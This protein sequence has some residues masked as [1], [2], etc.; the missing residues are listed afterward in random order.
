MADDFLVEP[1][2][3]ESR[4]GQPGMVV[5]DC[6]WFVPEFG[7]SGLDEFRNGHIAG[8]LYIDL[9]DIS[10]A[11]SPYVNML[12]SQAQFASEI[13]RLGISNNTLV[14]VCDAN[15][16]SARVWWMFRLFGHDRVRILN[17]GFRR[18]VAEGRPVETGDQAPVMPAVFAATPPAAQV[19]DWRQVL[20]AIDSGEATIA[21]ARTPGRFTGELSSGYPGVAGGH[22][23]TAVNIAW[24]QLIEQDGQ[25][26]FVG[27]EEVKR[28]LVNASVDLDKP[29]IATCGSGVTAAII[30][31]QLERMGMHDWRIYDASWHEWGQRT[32]LP[33][34]S[35]R[36]ERNGIGKQDSLLVRAG[37]NIHT[38]GSS[39]NPPVVRAS[40]FVF[41]TLDDFH[42]A[43]AKPF[44]GPF[45]GRIG[46][47]VT[48]A[49]EKAVAALEGG[50]SAIATSSGL[51]AIT[52]V[53]M[54]FLNKG[55]HVLVPDSVYDP[56]RRL[57][58]RTLSRMGI[59]T[60]YYD[61][62]IGAGIEALI[63]PETRLIYM[64]SPGSGTFEV[65]DVP[66][67]VRVAKTRGIRT[68]IDSTWATPLF[69]KP[70]KLG[71]DATIQAA[72][73]YIVGHSDAMLGVVTTV[74]DAFL[75]VRVALQDTGAC[76]GS[77]EAN[78]GLRGLRTMAVRLRHHQ[79]SGLRVAAWLAARPE[80]A[81][82]LH[83]GL[84]G[85]P[86]YDLWRRDFTGACGLFSFEF[87]PLVEGALEAFVDG[88]DYFKIGF[89]WG[90][91][92]SL[93]LPAHPERSRL[94][95]PWD[96]KGPLVRLHVGLEDIDD[97]IADLDAG[98]ARIALT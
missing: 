7:K 72:T 41:N 30:A 98:M 81:R 33:K 61:P 47:P 8:A 59:E 83:P 5:L 85:A 96:G 75:P 94:V 69:F 25:F 38:S 26:R 19:A 46:T 65:Q 43:A 79:A 18:W 77:E 36:V 78:L 3:L 4:L 73:K 82:V 66:A 48:L 88:L 74:G 42:K 45:Y 17:G 40:T 70:A 52:G 37:R 20:A 64:E 63:R 35:I 56:V 14:V 12:P 57:C 76:A 84:P 51:A 89:S 62:T 90:G 23:P 15:Y 31:F 1:E 49:F 34:R 54:A 58:S 80:V 68:A 2:W 16:V 39:V 10:D 95:K 22:M 92:E 91:Y 27:I 60:I 28:L 11:S 93:V 71:V 86:G 44:D 32:D 87:K 9:N 29:V 55:D 6:T 24:S 53:F 50:D 13:G 21:D 67:I 97:L